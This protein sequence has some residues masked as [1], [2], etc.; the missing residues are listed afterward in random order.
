MMKRLVMIL[1]AAVIIFGGR[2]AVGE[3]FMVCNV[4]S[5]TADRAIIFS[6][7]SLCPYQTEVR[8]RG[9]CAYG[10]LP[11][12]CLIQRVL[13]PGLGDT[14]DRQYGGVRNLSWV[15]YRGVPSGTWS[16]LRSVKFPDGAVCKIAEGGSFAEP[17]PLLDDC[18]TV[19]SC[20]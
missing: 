10:Q 7:G 9:Q 8:F 2:P 5:W 3:G 14:I 1:S 13:Y 16:L 20:C 18:M 4:S 19:T 17:D 15:D 11:A 6:Q 12:G